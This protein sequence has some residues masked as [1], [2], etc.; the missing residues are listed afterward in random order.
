MKP[1]I[2]HRYCIV[3]VNRDASDTYA[4]DALHCAGL[5]CPMGECVCPDDGALD[6]A[7]DAANPD[8]GD[9]VAY[10][11]VWAPDAGAARL[12]TPKHWREIAK[13]WW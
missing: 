9:T 12:M 10:A 1:C 13:G 5:D 8:A 11:F 4:A 7:V 6:V 3:R 2:L